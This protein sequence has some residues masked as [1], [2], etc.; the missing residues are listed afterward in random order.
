MSR[1]PSLPETSLDNRQKTFP[2]YSSS[3]LLDTVLSRTSSGTLPRWYQDNIYSPCFRNIISYIYI[4]TYNFI[5]SKYFS[6]EEVNIFTPCEQYQANISYQQ[7]FK[8]CMPPIGAKPL[9]K[10]MMIYYRWTLKKGRNCNQN[11]VKINSFNMMSVKCRPPCRY[12]TSNVLEDNI[13]W[14]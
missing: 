10:P 2:D 7:W 5:Y 11:T 12:L 6:K 8:L 4:Y 14:I 13:A 1:L 9:P 3:H